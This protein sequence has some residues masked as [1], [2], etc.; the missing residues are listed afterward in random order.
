MKLNKIN[1]IIDNFG[2]CNFCTDCIFIYILFKLVHLLTC[3]LFLQVCLN[4]L[5][6]ILLLCCFK[7]SLSQVTKPGRFKTRYKNNKH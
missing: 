6:R 5:L 7:Y 2:N 3:T 1:K 4:M